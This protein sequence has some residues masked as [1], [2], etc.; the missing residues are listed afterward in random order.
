MRVLHVMEATI[1]GTRRHLSDLALGERGAGLDVHVA[2][3]SLRVPDFERDLERLER[4][5]V[6]VTRIPMRREVAPALDRRHAAELRALLERLRPDVVH[7]HSSKAGALG[8]WAS[9]RSGIG[10]RVHTPHTF[11]FLFASMFGPGK[12]ALYRGVEGWLGART[13]RLI[14]VSQDEAR[15]I[16]AAGVV[17]AEK[18]RVVENGIDPRPYAAARALARASLGFSEGAPL[19]LTAGLLNIAKGQDLLVEALAQPGLEHVQL[20]LAGEG[21]LRPALEAR[22]AALGLGARV[23][24]LGFRADMPALLATCDAY[25]LP[26]RWEG[27]PYVLLEALSAC[28][29]IVATPVD[30]ARELVESGACGVLAQGMAPA[31]IAQALRTL[32]A[33]RAPERERLGRAGAEL[34][35]RRYTAERMVESTIAVYRELA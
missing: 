24:L 19:L 26:S 4:E 3:A 22:I 5:G 25:V 30:G 35:A 7:T 23:R 20:A 31:Q 28:K 9:L 6:G 27:M 18:L 14:A 15:T 2:A 17:A 34:V 12:R 13:Q 8:R 16:R 1:G 32:L 21:E 10:A 33:Q 29:P 11:A